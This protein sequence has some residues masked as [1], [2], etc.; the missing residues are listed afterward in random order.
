MAP[1]WGRHRGTRGRTATGNRRPHVHAV[2]D[3]AD[4]DHQSTSGVTCGY[5]ACTT[6][7]TLVPGGVLRLRGRGVAP[8]APGGAPTS[9]TS[10]PGFVAILTLNFRIRPVRCLSLSILT[11]PMRRCSP[12]PRRIPRQEP[13]R[14]HTRTQ[15]AETRLLRGPGRSRA[16]LGPLPVIHRHWEGGPREAGAGPVCVQ[17]VLPDRGCP[18][19]SPPYGKAPREV[20]QT[21][22]PSKLAESPCCINVQPQIHP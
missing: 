16:Y 2:D 5:G 17:K 4:S 19:P 3:T 11:P 18:G 8:P 7:A 14:D 1:R 20:S 9:K 22:A 15:D 12:S 10:T 13:A 21:T 6:A